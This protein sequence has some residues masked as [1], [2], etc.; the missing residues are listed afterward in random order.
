MGKLYIRHQENDPNV[1]SGYSFPST[2]DYLEIKGPTHAILLIL[3]T[4]AP[5]TD[6]NNA[7]NGSLYIDMTNFTLYRK[8]AAST[9][10]LSSA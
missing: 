7:A 10:T 8:T 4:G 3:G 6:H 5:S 2:S 1:D 9:W